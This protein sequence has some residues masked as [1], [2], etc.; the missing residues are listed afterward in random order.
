MAVISLLKHRDTADKLSEFLVIS[1]VLSAYCNTLATG[2][3]HVTRSSVFY[4]FLFV[5]F[6]QGYSEVYGARSHK[7]QLHYRGSCKQLTHQQQKQLKWRPNTCSF[8][9]TLITRLLAI[10]RPLSKSSRRL[11]VTTGM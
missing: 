1:S 2:A 8:R 11:P 5:G 7:Y 6:G 3:L 10:E 9:S 4:P